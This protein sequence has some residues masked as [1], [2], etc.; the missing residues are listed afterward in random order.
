MKSYV[1]QSIEAEAHRQAVDTRQRIVD[2]AI[3]AFRLH[4]EHDEPEAEF[5]ARIPPIVRGMAPYNRTAARLA[6]QLGGLS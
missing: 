3:V 4:Q 6:A 1:R 2:K 5:H